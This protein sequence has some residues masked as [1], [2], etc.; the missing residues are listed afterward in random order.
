MNI[1]NRNTFKLFAAVLIIASGCS[2]DLP[3]ASLVGKWT[4]TQFVA[5]GCTDPVDNV[6]NA[7]CS[8]GCGMEITATKFTFPSW[9]SLPVSVYDYTASAGLL[10]LTS[11][12]TGTIPVNYELTPGTLIISFPT[13]DGCTNTLY[14]TKA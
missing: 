3:Q 14:L 4:L 1:L 7:K 12:T 5:G 8:S 6:G 11:P 9:L 2:K 10:K 13:S